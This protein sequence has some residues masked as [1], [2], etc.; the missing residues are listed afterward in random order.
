MNKEQTADYRALE[1]KVHMLTEEAGQLLRV[2]RQYTETE[3][4]KLKDIRQSADTEGLQTELAALR[5]RLGNLVSRSRSALEEIERRREMPLSRDERFLSQLAALLTKEL[6]WMTA[7][8]KTLENASESMALSEKLKK[9][10]QLEKLRAALQK[11]GSNRQEEKE[12]EKEQRV[13]DS[14][15]DPGHS[16]RPR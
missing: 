12:H 1:N 16:G 10:T 4:M 15:M 3:G 7:M 5:L 9:E 6:E 8:E 11:H 13:P 2:I 14:R